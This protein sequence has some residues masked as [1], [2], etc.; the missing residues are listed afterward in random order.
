MWMD[1][2]ITVYPLHGFCETKKF[3]AIEFPN[4]FWLAKSSMFHFARDFT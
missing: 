4:P 1:G 3:P 2:P